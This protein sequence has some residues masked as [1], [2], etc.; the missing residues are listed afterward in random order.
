MASIV[1]IG[2]T[3]NLFQH[4]TTYKTV[5]WSFDAHT[6]AIL[7]MLDREGAAQDRVIMVD[8]SW[9]LRSGIRY[10]F[11]HGGYTNVKAADQEPNLDTAF[12]DAYIFLGH[13]LENA[14]YDVRHEPVD[15]KLCDTLWTST[16]NVHVLTGLHWDHDRRSSPGGR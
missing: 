4:A 14:P 3:I 8:W 6:P 7:E 1:F 11:Q 12:V 15:P 2:A 9:P 5:L 16:E 13:S 10:Y